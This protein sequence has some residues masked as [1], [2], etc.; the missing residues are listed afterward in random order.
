MSKI[1]PTWDEFIAGNEN[2]MLVLYQQHYLGLM[3]YGIKISG[4]RPLANECITQMLINLWDQKE[5]LPRVENIRAY[6]LTCLKRT[7][8]HHYRSEKLRA[9]KESSFQPDHSTE[10]SVDDYLSRIQ[11]NSIL[12]EKLVKAMEKLSPRQRELIKMRFFMD[13]N[14]D[15]IAAQCGI[16]KRTAYNIVNDGLKSLRSN[17]DQDVKDG[18]NLFILEF[19][20]LLLLFNRL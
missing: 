6:L 11:S 8:Y 1:M 7:I 12:K 5:K 10:L 17:F 9:V 20:T 4:S 3:N 16:T 18:N 2:A 15:E 19:I 14:Y 13:L